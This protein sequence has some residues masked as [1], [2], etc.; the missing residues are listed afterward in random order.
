LTCYKAGH[1][2]NFSSSAALQV[3]APDVLWC[4]AKRKAARK[5]AGT[6]RTAALLWVK[7]QPSHPAPI[8]VA[9]PLQLELNAAAM[10]LQ[11][12]STARLYRL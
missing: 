7:H 12:S 6:P 2:A 5:F 10:P 9:M 1:N 8:S 4:E 11:F 3:V